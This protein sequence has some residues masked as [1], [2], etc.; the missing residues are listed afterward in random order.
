M[1]RDTLRRN[2]GI[3]LIALVVTIIVLLI[4][5]GISIAMLTGQN[6]IL[7]RAAEAKEKTRAAQED[8]NEKLQGYEKIINQYAENLPI[9]EE[10]T[11]YLPNSTFSKKEGDLATGLVIQDANQNEYVWVEV[12]TT[13]YNNTTYN[14]NGANKPQNADEWKKIRDC[15]K[16]Y[17]SDY[18]T[19]DYKDT[20][21]DGTTYSDDYKNMLK[22]VY[23]NGGFWIGR[24]EAGLEG[25]TPR[26]SSTAISASDKAVVKQNKIPY[27][28]VTR[29]E[30]QELATR[31]N[32]NG[33]TS[34]L[35]FGIQWDL[36]LKYIEEKTVELAEEAN[37][38]T[39]RADIKSKLTSN[40]TTIGNYYNSEFTLNRGKFATYN[41][42]SDWKSYNSE[43]KQTLVTGSQKQAQSSNSNAILLTTGATDAT[44]LQNIY[45]IAGN[46]WEWTREIYATSN[47]CVVRGGCY[48]Y[49]GSNN[50]A[51]D[52][53]N[54][55]TSSSNSVVGFR[56]GLW[57]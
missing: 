47:P 22:S 18:S 41:D 57:K 16:A 29:D 2:K 26:I 50:P 13:I 46:V 12:P 8:E 32:Y 30:A 24:Y 53:S 28:F 7:N 33:C 39:V 10:T 54:D 15:L 40:S 3:T 34:S 36:T 38:D 20:N 45:D 5:A 48:Y 23:T 37:K 42:L 55:S 17:T 31:M 43:E 35:I 44:N 14:N 25:D 19:S 27:N 56:L 11:P 21:T 52:R 49:D 9:G 51:K 1:L 6:G 4:L